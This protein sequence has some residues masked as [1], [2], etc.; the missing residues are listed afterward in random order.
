MLEAA[1]GHM[2]HPQYGHYPE[3]R[4][5]KTSREQHSMYQSQSLQQAKNARETVL[6]SVE[7]SYT[8]FFL[9]YTNG[10]M[11]QDFVIS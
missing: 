11:N 9:N 3:Q 1:S 5:S 10:G 2:R 7:L 8:D 4:L 6:F